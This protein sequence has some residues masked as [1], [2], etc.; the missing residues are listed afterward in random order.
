MGEEALFHYFHEKIISSITEVC[1]EIK[2]KKFKTVLDEHILFD[3][4]LADNSEKYVYMLLKDT[5]FAILEGS[6]VLEVQNPERYAK[7]EELNDEIIEK[8][9]KEFFSTTKYS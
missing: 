7:L 6:D 2:N 9:S 5:V 1:R 4:M 3:I 8:G